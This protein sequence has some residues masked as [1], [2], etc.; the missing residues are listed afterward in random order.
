MAFNKNTVFIGA[1]IVAAQ[2]AFAS[3]ANAQLYKWTDE[4]GKVH[5]SDSVPPSANDRARK[6]IRPDGVVKKQVD[7]ALTP[8]ERRIAA[9]KAAEEEKVRIAKEE[10]E[11]KD[12]ALLTTYATLVDFD[13]VRDRAVA[14]A[15]A[16]IVALQKQEANEVAQRA[17]LQKQLDALGKKTVPVKLAKDV[18]N[19]DRELAVARDQIQKKTKDRAALVANYQTERVRLADLIAAEGAANKPAAS[20][21]PAAPAANAAK[22]KS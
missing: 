19:A 7:R 3:L 20:S 14:Q 13:R 1:L 21:A 22:K 11:R 10:R 15:D 18:E 17:D 5:Y 16:E 6:E 4:N 2:V 9:Q 12:K 8:E